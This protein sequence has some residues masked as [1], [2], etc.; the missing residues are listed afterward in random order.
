MEVL[1]QLRRR[2]LRIPEDI[3]VVA[4]DGFPWTELGEPPLT[5]VAQPVY[6]MGQEAARWL[7]AQLQGEAPRPGP[8]LAADL[9]ERRSVGR[10][11]SAVPLN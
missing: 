3:S 5:V 11:P 1:R 6:D 10:A 8:S 7:L 4:Y 9:V 2:G